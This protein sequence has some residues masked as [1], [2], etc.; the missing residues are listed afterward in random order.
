[1]ITYPDDVE[2]D[3]ACARQL[4][5]G[6]IN[7][8]TMEKRYV[9]KG[10]SVAWVNLTVSLL[11]DPAGFPQHFISIIDDITERKQVQLALADQ[12]RLLKSVTGAARVGLAVIEPGYVYR[13]AN[14]AYGEIL[15]IPNVTSI[16]G[17]HVHEMVPEG[18]AQI[19]PRL[20]RAFRGE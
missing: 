14:K 11:R 13:F 15:G 8:Y 6:D 4:L 9:R 10:G 3:W 16:I 2:A 20:D 18:W 5:A 12:E 17:R 19:Q 7:I 1:D